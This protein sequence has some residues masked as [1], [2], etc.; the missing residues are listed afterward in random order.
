MDAV[1]ETAIEEVQKVAQTI[2][3][4]SRRRTIDKLRDL[5]YAL[6]TPEETMQRLIY[7][8]SDNIP[9]LMVSLLRTY[10]GSTLHPSASVST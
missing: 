10:R 7:A 2:N 3:E 6:E 4:G 9:Y 5:Q 1:L 8:V